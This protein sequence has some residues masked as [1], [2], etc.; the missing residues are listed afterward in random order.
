MLLSFYLHIVLLISFTIFSFVAVSFIQRIRTE[1]N[2][3]SL[4]PSAS[5]HDAQ[6]EL[7]SV[8]N[9]TNKSP[10][11][12]SVA[13]IDESN[14]R[15]NIFG[16]PKAK[17]PILD[18]LT[19]INP[20]NTV[21]IYPNNMENYMIFIVLSRAFNF[22]FRQAIRGTWGRS[23]KYKGYNTTIKTIFFVGIDDSVQSAVR[24]E[25][26]RFNDVIEIAIPESYAF[27]AHKELASLLWTRL[28][29][30]LA[31]ILFRADDDI[32]MDTFLLL[33][34]IKDDLNLNVK[35]GL[36]G[37]FRFNNTV[38]RGDRWAVTKM[39]Y[40]P[41]TYPPY[42]FGV[43]YLFSNFSCQRLVNAANQPNHQIVRI[44][45]AYITGILRDLAEIPFY[46]FKDL[47]FSYTFYNP[48]P[49]DEYFMNNPQLLI[50]MSKLHT[51]MRDD[52]LEFYDVW[53]A[54][55][56]KYEKSLSDIFD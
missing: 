5:V 32:L 23:E 25:Q 11:N 42:T 56:T 44:G 1:N 37:W 17:N 27:V 8:A 54:I 21:C 43:G 30:P 2:L 55:L 39:E 13:R 26:A 20:P 38:H 18:R 51:G 12:A 33:N 41:N 9:G 52:P 10:S 16:S 24:L 28:Y 47:K 19:F 29:C 48:I 15:E 45:D 50:C 4:T 34:F 31:R 7:H 35:D 14:L 22:D 40:K 36:Y 3:S 53:D 6:I 49:C 46:D